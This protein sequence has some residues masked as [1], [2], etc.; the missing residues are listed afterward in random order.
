[1]D[2]SNLPNWIKVFK[3]GVDLLMKNLWARH[4]FVHN[5]CGSEYNYS[6][7]LH[8]LADY[9][10]FWFT[11]TIKP[12]S[13]NYIEWILRNEMYFLPVAADATTNGFTKEVAEKLMVMYEECLQGNFSSVEILREESLCSASCP[14]SC[15]ETTGIVE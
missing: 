5:K 4:V 9:I 13:F 11:Q 7:M 2:G 10:L 1:M 8:Q 15:N 3:E 14:T 6:M 12:V